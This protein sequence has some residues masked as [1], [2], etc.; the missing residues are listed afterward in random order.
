MP[1]ALVVGPGPAADVSGNPVASSSIWWKFKTWATDIA[2]LPPPPAGLDPPTI[3]ESVAPTSGTSA[4]TTAAAVVGDLVIAVTLT[5]HTSAITHTLQGGWT[6][7][8]GSTVDFGTNEIRMTVAGRVAFASGVQ[9]YNPVSA[10]AGTSYTALLVLESGTYDPDWATTCVA[11]TRTN[12]GDQDADP[13]QV[14]AT[15]A[16]LVLAIAGYRWTSSV[17]ASITPPSGYTEAVEMAGANQLELSIATKE[18]TAG[19]ENP[20]T[21]TDG[22][23]ADGWIAITVAILGALAPV[24]VTGGPASVAATALDATA[25]PGA[26]SVTG[27]QADTPATALDGTATPGAVSSTG[28]PAG[29]AATALDAVATP[30]SASVTG[31][32]AD[33][34]ATGLDA[35]AST[36]ATVTGAPADTSATGLDATAA[37][38][39]ATATG[40]PADV[41]ATALDASVTGGAV[42]ASGAPASTTATA[43]DATA[44]P[45]AASA[46]GSPADA[47]AEALDAFAGG[48]VVASGAPADTSAS[49][50]DATATAGPIAV[51]GAPASA[52]A[53]SLDAVALAGGATASGSPA[54]APAETPGGQAI[55]G[56]VSVTGGV[57]DAAADGLD[58]AAA[59]VIPV[60]PV[61]PTIENLRDHMIG[62][63]RT[64]APTA[65]AGDSFLPYE[66]EGDGDFIEWTMSVG[67]GAFRRF[68]IRDTGDDLGAVGPSADIEWREATF[69]ITLAY[70][71]DS[72]AGAAGALDRDDLMRADQEL[73][74]R[75]IGMLAAASFQGPGVPNASWLGSDATRVIGDGVD[76][77]IVRQRMGFW[78]LWSTPPAA[79]TPTNHPTTI[80]ALRDHVLELVEGV[81]PALLTGDRF[82]RFV[83]ER[84]ADFVTATEA[85]AAGSLRRV[86]VRDLV[87]A[88]LPDVSDV[89]GE[90]RF[91][92]LQVEVAYP[93]TS[94]AGQDSALDRDDLMR[95]DQLQI[96]QAIGLAGAA[97]FAG[98]SAPNAAWVSG[99]CARVIGNGVDYLVIRQTMRFQRTYP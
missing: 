48:G 93:Q 46:S 49:A 84:D 94:R 31:A 24:Q 82:E 69:E 73:V 70:P 16:S 85:A 75:T 33:T 5:D 8:A 9:S 47:T 96:E 27:A 11:D 22:Q 39:A 30:G 71:Q 1:S 21:F 99:S 20:G 88:R 56:P 29:A 77:L 80:E 89:A 86:H 42:S 78:F 90:G 60:P 18:V 40:G 38:G 65:M 14:T 12:V 61:P 97:N 98:P 51:T 36:S 64:A 2:Q 7:L 17:T 83:P 81:T 67:A 62:L 26:A 28:A 68:Q 15:D 92:I 50:L 53:T 4:S 79:Y 45:G 72:R 13:E 3:R 55:P 23:T 25:T 74:E 66:Q 32:P 58:A 41:A 10:S 43:L 59:I 35:T 54:D 87:A 91:V 34:A 44:T 95:S 57:A 76:F 6:Q 37:G 52:A 63:L 19:A